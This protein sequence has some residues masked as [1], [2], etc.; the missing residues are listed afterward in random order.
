METLDIPTIRDLED[1]I[2]DAIYH[3]ILRAKLDQQ[4]KQVDVD[5]TMGR[6]LPPGGGEALLKVLGAW[7][8]DFRETVVLFA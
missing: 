6:D 4:R 3:D 5:F 8:V 2:I 1:L 7:L